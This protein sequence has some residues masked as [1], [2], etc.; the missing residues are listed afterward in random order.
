MQEY[1]EQGFLK[2]GDSPKM[3]E[4]PKKGPLA[5]E[6][7]V[8]MKYFTQKSGETKKFYRTPDLETLLAHFPSKMENHSLE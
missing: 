3:G 2:L 7:R 6:S 4:N 8:K 5:F 1:L